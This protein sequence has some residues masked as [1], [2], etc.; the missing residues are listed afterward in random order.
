M[1]KRKMTIKGYN[2]AYIDIGDG[3][4]IVFLHGNPTSSY[5]WRN[6]FPK[7]GEIGRC[8]IPDLIGMG[9]SDK[10]QNATLDDY[11]Y[12][13][14]FN[15]LSDFLES[16][17]FEEKIILVV[18]DWGS[19]LGFNW[20]NI[21]EEKIK[22]ICYM[23]SIVKPFKWEEFPKSSIPIFKNLRGIDG[24]K[25][26]L[27]KN[28]FIEHILPKSILRN[29]SEDE[30]NNYRNPFLGDKIKRLPMLAW[31]RL[32]PIENE[33]VKT[34]NIVSNYSK[35]LSKTKINKLFIEGKPGALMTKD[36]LKFCKS[37]K[38]QDIGVVK[39]IHFLQEDSPEEISQMIYD[40]IKKI[41]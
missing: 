16:F 9:D 30:M 15:F 18:H 13:N 32:L 11:S 35:W 23:E 19:A 14:H 7:L 40:W 1:F 3:V 38:N 36:I 5:L 34:F 2:I 21:N 6:I 39:G 4:P 17:N 12:E 33:P 31:P 20:A 22:G 29:L 24:E 10:I 27:E 37:F 8:I 26:I 41:Y 25:M 28:I